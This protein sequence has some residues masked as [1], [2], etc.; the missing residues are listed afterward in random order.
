MT[1]KFLDDRFKKKDGEKF[2]ERLDQLW[3]KQGSNPGKG[4]F[5][6]RGS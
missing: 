2:F 3:E 4:G 6:S 5:A 1:R